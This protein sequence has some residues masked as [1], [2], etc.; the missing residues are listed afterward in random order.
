LG[1]FLVSTDP[2]GAAAYFRLGGPLRARAP[3]LVEAMLEGGALEL[4]RSRDVVPK[5]FR[6]VPSLLW[7]GVPRAYVDRGSVVLREEWE[8]LSPEDLRQPGHC[9]RVIGL[10]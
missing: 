8:R 5:V 3:D 1:Q 7:A 2:A 6:D 10:L 4:V 9:L